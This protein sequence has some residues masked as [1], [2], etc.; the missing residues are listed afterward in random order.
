LLAS[1]VKKGGES[2]ETYAGSDNQPNDYLVILGILQ[3]LDSFEDDIPAQVA[4]LI[5]D[6]VSA[7]YADDDPFGLSGDATAEAGE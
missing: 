3:I 4:D 5:C 7:A 6:R 2:W 1:L